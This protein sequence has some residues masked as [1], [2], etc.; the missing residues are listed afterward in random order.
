[1]TR[2]DD[3]R[4]LNEVIEPYNPDYLS[5][6]PYEIPQI[7]AYEKRYLH[8]LSILENKLRRNKIKFDWLEDDECFRIWKY[9]L[10]SEYPSYMY[11]SVYMDENKYAFGGETEDVC[12][13][14][15]ASRVVEAALKWLNAQ[16]SVKSIKQIKRK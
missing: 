5:D 2:L 10:G 13:D 9:K 4:K 12:V 6:K 7:S 1:M 11:L 15:H 3:L 16:Y 8:K 14:G